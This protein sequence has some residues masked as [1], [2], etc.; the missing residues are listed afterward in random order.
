MIKK[1]ENVKSWIFDLDETLYRP[2]SKIANQVSDKITEF[3]MLEYGWEKDIAVDIK[4]KYYYE[5]G[6]TLQGLIKEG[7]L[8]DAKKF[9]TFCHDVDISRLEQN[10][11]LDKALKKL[12]GKKYILTTSQSVYAEKVLDAL[13]ILNHFELIWG[14]EE[15][16]F[17]AKPD[18]HPYKKLITEAELDIDKTA[19]FEDSYVNITKAKEIGL[20]TVWIDNG[21]TLE[22]NTKYVREVDS[23]L[24]DVRTDDIVETINDIAD[25]QNKF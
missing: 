9:E 15:T 11:A 7:K 12:Q 21:A 13:G 3:L 25:F 22:S 20:K 17:I 14:L 18:V 16:D 23:S 8:E 6:S 24:I 1:L 19:M 5:Y 10:K 2:D 4:K